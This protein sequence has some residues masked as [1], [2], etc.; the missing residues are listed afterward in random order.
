MKYTTSWFLLVLSI[1][2]NATYLFLG[3]INKIKLTSLPI[4]LIS[5]F[6]IF[7]TIVFGEVILKNKKNGSNKRL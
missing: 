7:T 1:V 5:I 4:T 2:T 6:G 3:L